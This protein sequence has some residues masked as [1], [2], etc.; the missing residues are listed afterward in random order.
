MKHLTGFKLFENTYQ[1]VILLKFLE[2]KFYK[3]N[4]RP[5]DADISIKMI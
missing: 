5:Y 4:K 2:K 3:Y 1:T